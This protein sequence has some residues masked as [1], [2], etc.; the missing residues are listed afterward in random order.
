MQLVVNKEMKT[1]HTSFIADKCPVC[2]EHIA[3]S[4]EIFLRASRFE[5]A[6]V[7]WE[8]LILPLSTLMSPQPVK[9]FE[10]W[11]SN[12][13]NLSCFS[14]LKE[15]HNSASRSFFSA[16]FEKNCYKSI[17][18]RKT[19]FLKKSWGHIEKKQSCE[20][21]RCQQAS[22]ERWRRLTREI[23]VSLDHFS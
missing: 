19:Q 8:M 21:Q 4:V 13:L 7:R 3:L 5:P 10:S 20:L 6:T 18:F 15:F 16:W 2:H 14:Q 23:S 17:F 1:S 22:N 9:N 11:H 12:D